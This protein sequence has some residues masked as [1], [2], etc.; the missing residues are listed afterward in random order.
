M[1]TLTMEGMLLHRL[2]TWLQARALRRRTL[3]LWREKTKKRTSLVRWLKTL[4][5]THPPLQLS[6]RYAHLLASSRKVCIDLLQFPTAIDL[7]QA[8]DSHFMTF[9][10][11]GGL[12]VFCLYLLHHNKK[13]I[14]GTSMCSV[15]WGVILSGDTCYVSQ[16]SIEL[17]CMEK[18]SSVIFL[19]WGQICVNGFIFTSCTLFPWR[20]SRQ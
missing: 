11:V 16:V 3:S 15:L 7:E 18:H 20:I 13:K 6:I 14:L 8:E 5:A 4:R 9:I 12:L 19:F 1:P 2:M 10:V 17:S